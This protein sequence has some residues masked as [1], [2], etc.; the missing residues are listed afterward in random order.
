MVTRRA[1]IKNGKIVNVFMADDDFVAQAYPSDV[2][3]PCP[4][5]V[6]R[7]HHW[8]GTTFTPPGRDV[9][10]EAANMRGILRGLL[11]QTDWTQAGDATPQKIAPWKQWRAGI[12]TMLQTGTDQE[13]ADY[14]IPDT[15]EPID[16]Y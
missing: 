12:R 6:G 3:V 15:P 14:V 8:D 5:S 2:V 1:L 7:G 11:R 4:D 16:A 13:L 10:L 9:A